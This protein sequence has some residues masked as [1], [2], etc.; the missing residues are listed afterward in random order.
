MIGRRVIEVAGS[1]VYRVLTAGA[2]KDY[3]FS[4]F[5]MYNCIEQLCR[6]RSF[7][8]P[9][10]CISHSR[11]LL[12]IMGALGLE[13]EEANFP[14]VNILKLPYADE[15][16]GLVASDQVFEHIQGLPSIAFAETL[17]VTKK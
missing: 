14:K 10:L 12:P 17:R 9:A 4:R 1:F 6:G 5:G 15:Q 11:H 16:F 7:E 3:P 8:G 2:A 13:V